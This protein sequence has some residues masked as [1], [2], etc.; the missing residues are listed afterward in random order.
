MS[1]K[2][3]YDKNCIDC[4]YHELTDYGGLCLL[5]KIPLVT[6]DFK[7]CEDWIDTVSEVVLN[8]LKEDIVLDDIPGWKRIIYPCENCMNV[9]VD[10]N[11]WEPYMCRVDGHHS[12]L[13]IG[14]SD[15]CP[16]KYPIHK[17]WIKTENGVI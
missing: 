16:Y 5:K 10:V 17:Q 8:E 1:V 2:D 13:L 15:K 7:A 9:C 4:S 6:R 11:H 12:G 14:L 3:S